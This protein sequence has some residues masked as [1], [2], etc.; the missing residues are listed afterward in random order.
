[1]VE[2]KKNPDYLRKVRAAVAEFRSA[3]ESFLEL[4]ATNEG[5]TGV[6]RALMPAVFPEEGFRRG[7]DRQ[8]AVS[9]RSGGRSGCS[10]DAADRVLGRVP[11]SGRITA[12][13]RPNCV[14]GDD[15]QP[16]AAA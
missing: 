15:D 16:Q 9:G 7:R 11:T 5:A 8:E 2:A 10:R 12:D 6:A 4:H 13:G 3:L 14:L 1:M